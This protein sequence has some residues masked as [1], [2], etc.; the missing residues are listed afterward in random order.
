MIY[1][2]K[3]I[4]IRTIFIVLIIL[5]IANITLFILMFALDWEEDFIPSKTTHVWWFVYKE[6]IPAYTDYIWNSGIILSVLCLC[7]ICFLMLQNIFNRTGLPEIFFSIFFILSISFESLRPFLIL[8]NIYKFPV[9][10][11][12]FISRIIYFFRFYGLFSLLFTSLYIL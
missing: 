9:Y 6:H 5:I 11:G 12:V 3:N 8:I 7:F 4:I 10:I 1:R 2:N